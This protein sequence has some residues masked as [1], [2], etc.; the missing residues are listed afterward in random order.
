MRLINL[1][2]NVYSLLYSNH[3]MHY[4]ILLHWTQTTTPLDGGHWQLLW[5]IIIKIN[6][7]VTFLLFYTRALG[8]VA[9]ERGLI[10]QGSSSSLISGGGDRR[11]GHHG[12]HKNWL[13]ESARVEAVLLALA[14]RPSD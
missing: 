9:H 5:T 13:V 7:P 4:T 8:S 2:L 11:E 10:D 14:G 12:H 3:T 6:I 1:T